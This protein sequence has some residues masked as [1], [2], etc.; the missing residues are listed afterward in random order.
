MLELTTDTRLDVARS[1]IVYGGGVFET[2]R[3]TRSVPLFL[4]RHL[5]R[6]NTGLQALEMASTPPDGTV[7]SFIHSYLV[8][9]SLQE[10]A[11]RLL[12]VDDKLMVMRRNTYPRPTF[13]EIE[14]APR[15]HRTSSSSLQ[16]IKSA[17]YLENRLL[18]LRAQQDGLFDRIACNER[19]QLTDGGRCNLF[20]VS[21]NQLLTPPVT[22]GALPGVTR[23]VLLD[24]PSVTEQSLTEEDLRTAPAGCVTSS[25]A[26]VLPVNRVRGVA[27]WDPEHPVLKSISEQYDRTVEDQ[28]KRYSEAGTG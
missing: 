5:E 22:D 10:G 13:T 12:A 3:V 23:T 25:L 8:E 16:G 4:D 24:F 2:V 21:G 11:L 20:V 26:G 7:R 27:E 14:I 28:I 18:T 9:E 17:A 6:M 15:Y 1:A 19:G